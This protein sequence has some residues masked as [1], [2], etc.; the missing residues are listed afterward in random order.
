MTNKPKIFKYCTIKNA[1]VVV[2]GNIEFSVS[3]SSSLKDFTKKA[4]RSL[5]P[6]YSKFFKMDDISRLAFICAE[7]LFKDVDIED[8]SAKDISVVLT[9]SHST[10]ET[11]INHQSTISYENNFYPSPAVFVYTLP[12]I[13]IGEI[14]IRHKLQGENAFFIVEKFNSDLLAGY[15]NK[16]FLKNKSSIVVGGWVNF[17]GAD[18]D[19]FLYLV[20]NK[21]G[22][23]QHNSEELYKIYNLNYKK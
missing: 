14:S 3:D 18:Y 21:D 5:S 11:D 22:N 7:F 13:M 2:D 8:F 6:S 1:Q 9:N 4:Y 19:A 10:L 12:N 17:T 20:S 23:I 15:I 16:L